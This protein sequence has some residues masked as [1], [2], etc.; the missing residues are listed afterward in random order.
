ML[1]VF[2]ALLACYGTLCKLYDVR[3]VSA[4]L[5]LS[6]LVAPCPKVIC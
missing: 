5:L 2:V 3:N 6:N 4:L 1:I